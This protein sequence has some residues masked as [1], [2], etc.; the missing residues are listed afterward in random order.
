M[1]GSKAQIEAAF[2][3]YLTGTLTRE[4]AATFA[5]LLDRLYRASKTESRAGFP[6]LIGRTKDGETIKEGEG[7]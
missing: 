1:K 2:Y 7:E 3:E 4:E 5:S 6:H